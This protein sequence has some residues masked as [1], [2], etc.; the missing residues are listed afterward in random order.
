MKPKCAVSQ[1]DETRIKNELYLRNL[2]ALLLYRD[3]EGM[4]VE[5]NTNS[6]HIY[7]VICY[8]CYL[9]KSII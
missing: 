9:I 4:A 2:F 7:L 1:N 3:N 6:A 8:F 5:I